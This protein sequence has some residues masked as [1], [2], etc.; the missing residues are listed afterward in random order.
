MVPVVSEP[1]QCKRTDKRSFDF[2]NISVDLEAY[3]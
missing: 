1:I 3:L 2:M